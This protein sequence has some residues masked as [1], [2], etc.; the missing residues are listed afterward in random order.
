MNR[1][2]I[3]VAEDDLALLETLAIMLKEKYE[4]YTAKNGEELIRLFKEKRPSVVVTDILMPEVD[5][6]E[7]TKKSSR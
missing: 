2:K 7:A 6:V 3:I 1:E 4:V 5:G